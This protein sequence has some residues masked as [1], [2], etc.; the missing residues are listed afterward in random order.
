MTKSRQEPE[1]RAAAGG[2]TGPGPRCDVR[3]RPAALVGANAAVAPAAS[4]EA[5]AALLVPALEAELPGV[6]VQVSVEAEATTGLDVAV[7]P[8]PDGTLTLRAEGVARAVR[9]AGRWTVYED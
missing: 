3:V 8:D 7:T 6:R 5:Y 2:E 4:A 1:R 9:H